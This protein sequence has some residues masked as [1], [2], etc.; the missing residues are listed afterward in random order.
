MSPLWGSFQLSIVFY[1]NAAPLELN[2][3]Y[4]LVY[5]NYDLQSPKVIVPISIQAQDCYSCRKC[6]F[7]E[8]QRGE[9]LVES[10]V[11]CLRAPAGRHS[12]GTFQSV[13]IYLI[14]N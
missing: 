4:L 14:F 5:K 9:I 8:P 2:T 10:Y 6:C 1:K 3:K 7:F 12:Y 11:F 13:F